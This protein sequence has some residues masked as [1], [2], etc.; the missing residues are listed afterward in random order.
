MENVPQAENR[1]R[2]QS[3]AKPEKKAPR[4]GVDSA[5]M[6]AK[7]RKDG[8]SLKNLVISNVYTRNYLGVT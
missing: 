7:T 2:G 4:K 1:G 6:K 8:L 3:D 5:K